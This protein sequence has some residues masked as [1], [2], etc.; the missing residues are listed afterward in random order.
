M[1]SETEQL[2]TWLRTA[3]A[4]RRLTQADV[5]Q[6][7][8]VNQSQISRILRGHNKRTSENVAVLCSF[9]R[10]EIQSMLGA[11][12]VGLEAEAQGILRNLMNGSDHE[13]RL[14]VDVL[15]RLKVL[16]D[17]WRAADDSSK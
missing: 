10:H 14:V 3:V 6:K 9:A 5:A 17:T 4:D 2:L 1:D 8:G 15:R 11:G 7:T 13:R 12:E 16:R